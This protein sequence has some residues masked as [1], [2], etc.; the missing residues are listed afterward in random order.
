MENKKINN[1][2]QKKTSIKGLLDSPEKFMLQ[3][4]GEYELISEMS[5][6]RSY[7]KYQ[8]YKIIIYG[9]GIQCEFLIS[10]LN[11]EKV[12]VE[13]II[14]KNPCKHNEKLGKYTIYDCERIPEYLKK[15]KY[16]V[17]I[18]TALFEKQTGEI[19]YTL[20]KN[21]IKDYIYPFDKI[22]GLA[23]YRFKWAAYWKKHEEE[24]IHVYEE[25]IDEESKETYLEFVK[26]IISN[27]V[28]RKKQHKSSEKYFEKYVKLQ[29]E[30]FLNI[31]S[32][33]GDTIFY[34][35]ENRNEKFEKIYACEGD[36]E[37]FSRLEKNLEM[38]PPDLKR[39]IVAENIYLDVENIKK[40]NDKKVTLV[41][42]DVEGAE[43]ELIFG[44]RDCILKSRPVLAVCA[45]HKPEDIIELP[46]MIRKLFK[47]YV[48]LFRKYVSSYDC[49]LECS[50]LVMYAIPQERYI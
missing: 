28:Y 4:G 32:Y 49:R 42:M 36:Y 3:A 26:S 19:L 45:Y 6:L 18:S 40:Y 33:V 35:L 1:L 48:I 20:F 7:I 22:Y 50:E 17:L 13:F 8:N 46:M 25:L 9:A 14:D 47:N 16:L 41:S 10:W 30:C 21:G 11:S 34:F 38:L 12:P 44:L 2:M 43:K 23:P 31:G 15:E 39:K 29:D 37:I 24:L 5:F 27:R